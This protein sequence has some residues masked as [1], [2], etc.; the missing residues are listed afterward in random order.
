M[1]KAYEGGL[2]PYTLI[3]ATENT[4]GTQPADASWSYFSDTVRGFDPSGLDPGIEGQRG[5]GDAD[6]KDHFVG[7]GSWGVEIEYDLQQALTSGNDAA[8]DG[9]T[10][11]TYNRLPNSH[12]VLRKMEQG[13]IKAGDTWNGSTSKDTYKWLVLMGGKIDTVTIMGDPT[14]AQPVTVTLEYL[15]EKAEVHQ[16]DQPGSDQ[17]LTV[18]GL[19]SGTSI[20]IEDDSGNSET[21]SSDGTTTATYSS[22]NRAYLSQEQSADVTVDGNSSGDQ[23]LT[24]YGSDNYDYNVGDRGVVDVGSGSQASSIGNAYE[25]VQGD[26]IERPGGTDLAD[27]INSFEF[28][29]ENNVTEESTTTGNRPLV[30]AEERVAEVAATLF[31]EVEYF[32][33][34]IDALQATQNDVKWTLDNSTLTLTNGT[35]VE[36]GGTEDAG[37]GVKAVDVTFQ[38]T[39]VSVS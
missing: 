37:Q 36:V 10:R 34:M 16:F 24:I 14:S 7:T 19:A 31:G 20:T 21:L 39:G 26:T 23:L 33:N 32:S 8:N 17:S 6:F 1:S 13:D 12:T 4:E 2:R 25:V 30:V 3:W 18:S 15:F 5:L 38:G 28:T 9:L 29:V 22:I 27:E 11:D 35:V